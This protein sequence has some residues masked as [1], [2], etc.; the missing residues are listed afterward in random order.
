MRGPSPSNPPRSPGWSPR[1]PQ[2]RALGS[3][4]RAPG[5]APASPD[6]EAEHCSASVR[7]CLRRP[8]YRYSSATPI[9]RSPTEP[10]RHTRKIT[11]R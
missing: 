6:L 1:N 4:Q 3:D 11:T 2:Q 9:G 8:R 10:D 5:S 7:R